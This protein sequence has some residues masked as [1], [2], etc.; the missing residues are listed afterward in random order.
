[1][2]DGGYFLCRYRLALSAFLQS[3]SSLLHAAE[4]IASDR[5]FTSFLFRL[6]PPF[7]AF[8]ISRQR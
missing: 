2:I 1:M 3:A 5:H 7:Q 4:F 6:L 8:A